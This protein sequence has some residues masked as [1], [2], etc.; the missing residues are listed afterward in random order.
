MP[1][2]KK[3]L[4]VGRSNDLAGLDRA[5]YRALE[6]LPGALAWAT[7]ALVIW[8]SWKRPIWV[9]IFIIVFDLYWLIKTIFL[10]FH[11]R[12]NWKRMQHNLTIDW[13]E[14]LTM[15][16][17]QSLWQLVV[18]PTVG[19]SAA[20]IRESLDTI[21]RSA[22]PKERMFVVLAM[23]DAE[24][25]HRLLGEE[26]KQ[27]YGEM[28]GIFLVT[29]H[30]QG[31][32][33]EMRGKGSNETWAVHEAKKII[34]Q[35]KIPYEDI[36]VSSFDIDT[37]LY[38]Q[39]FPCLAWHF[40]TAEKPHRSSFQPVPL[41]HNNVWDAG[42]V[43]RVVASSGT[44]W[45]MMQQERPE[46]LTTFSSHSMSFKSLVEIGYWQVNIVSED[47]RIF[48]N[49]FFHYNGDWRAVPLAYPVSM[50][51]NL[52]PSLW[53]TLKNIY[54]Q[55]RRWGWGVENVP[56]VLFGFL[57]NRKIALS[58][59]LRFSFNLLEGFWSWAT[60]ALLIFAL[61][62]LPVYLSVREYKSYLIL[63][64]LPYITR[65]IMILSMFG[66]ITSAVI[67]QAMLRKTKDDYLKQW[68][69]SLVLQWFL[70]PATIIIFGALPGL[71]AQ[72]RL[73]LGGKFRLGFWV[74]P[75]SRSKQN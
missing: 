42:A 69:L 16:K 33:G 72:T 35:R 7:I 56:Y 5:L 25:A 26:M 54:R 38:Q 21:A 20:V 8:F 46:R 50:D 11:L 2:P 45:Q 47:S 41:Y 9:A 52:A 49:H 29:R 74:T 57:K 53:G 24:E 55:Q 65:N 34:D 17:W 23:E 67:T 22:W 70:M 39:F 6:I 44:F 18:L 19:E 40:L 60:N 14:R 73:A 51:A 63:Y 10:S 36:I 31:L 32:P 68:S 12:A 28:F 37:K 64:N 48:W 15:L 59:K 1:Y 4:Y 61:G 3:Y 71:E 66:I 30:P 62:W 75:K 58:K 27:V 13:N 43:S